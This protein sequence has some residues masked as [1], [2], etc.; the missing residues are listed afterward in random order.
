[1]NP[2]QNQSRPLERSEEE[3]VDFADIQ[4]ARQTGAEGRTTREIHQQGEDR[5]WG[6]I[7][8]A[9]AC[10]A[11]V[12]C[13]T[14]PRMPLDLAVRCAEVTFLYLRKL[15]EPD[16]FREV[17]AFRDSQD[18]GV[19]IGYGNFGYHLSQ[20]SGWDRWKIECIRQGNQAFSGTLQEALTAVKR[21]LR[22]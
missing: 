18:Q 1:M 14:G 15:S 11:K 8:V 10:A 4:L 21:D 12:E 9:P 16:V 7:P 19:Y 20:Q 3:A 5:E 2:G 22:L 13:D 17:H 6:E